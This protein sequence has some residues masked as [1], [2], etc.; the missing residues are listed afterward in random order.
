MNLQARR[1]R[2]AVVADPRP[3][4]RTIR[5]TCAVNHNN[6]DRAHSR[7]SVWSGSDLGRRTC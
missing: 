2:R 6:P 5:P 1:Q 3:S 4:R 7:V